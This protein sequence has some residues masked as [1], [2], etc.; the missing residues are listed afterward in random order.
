V[1]TQESY[2]EQCIA[3]VQAALADHADRHGNNPG[4]VVIAAY[5]RA[6]AERD[7]MQGELER[8]LT[9]GMKRE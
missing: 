5:R 7:A 8:L 1:T 6:K 9:V 2:T 3:Y 4:D